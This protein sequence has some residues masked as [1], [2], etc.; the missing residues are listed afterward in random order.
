MRAV[1][2]RKTTRRRRLS[3]A[4]I[5][6]IA[7]VVAAG[8]AGREGADARVVEAAQ[9]QATLAM[10]VVRVAVPMALASSAEAVQLHAY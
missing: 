4:A 3:A 10:P 7:A 5:T 8:R 1:E 6:L 2:R 9:M